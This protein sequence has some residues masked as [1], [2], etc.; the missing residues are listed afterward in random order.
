MLPAGVT[1]RDSKDLSVREH[2]YTHAEWNAFV[3]GVKNGEFDLETF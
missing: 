2:R 3:L 1:M